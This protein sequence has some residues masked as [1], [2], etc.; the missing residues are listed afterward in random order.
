MKKNMKKLGLS[1]CAVLLLAGCSCK[2]EEDNSVK[3]NINNGS[4]TIVAGLGEDVNS[5]TL[6]KLYDDLKSQLGNEVAANKLLKYVADSIKSD[7]TWNERYNAKI[8]EKLLKL[9]EDKNYQIDGVFS[10]ELLVKSLDVLYNVT[11][12]NNTY[13]PTYKNDGTIDEYLLCDYTS[14]INKVLDLEVL[15][16]L[17]NEKY[18]YDKVLKDKTNLLTTKKV[19]LVEYISISSNEDYSFDFLTEAVEKLSAENSTVSLEDVKTLWEEK[20]VEELMV[21]YNKI[22]TKDDANGSIYQEF[23]G[24]Y[25]YTKDEGLELK[26]KAIYDGNYYDKVVITSDSNSILNATLIERILSENVLS[27][28][29]EKAIEIN[30]SYYLVSPLAG[31]NVEVSDIRITDTTNSK[32]YLIKVDVINADSSEDLIYE[33]VKV[34]ATNSSLVSDS[35]N[36]YLEQEKNNISAHDEEIYAYLKT[37]Y[38]K[39]FVD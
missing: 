36:Y 21:K 17:L 2:K 37:Q 5:D 28:T 31:S 30:G 23:T 8:N 27:E 19:R 32:Y 7:A 10:E 4:E 13:G 15:T 18:V 24:N 25:E 33:A 26:K 1:L 11:C 20:L 16:E 3:A 9:T 6:Q 14:Y 34:L 39:I 22:N 35:I 29:A 12:E 38:E